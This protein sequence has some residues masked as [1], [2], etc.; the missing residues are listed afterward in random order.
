[1]DVAGVGTATITD[2]TTALSRTFVGDGGFS[3]QI[4][5]FSGSL[6]VANSAFTSYDLSHSFGP[7]SGPFSS[8]LTGGP[9]IDTSDGKLTFSSFGSTGTFTATPEPASLTLLGIGVAGMM[10]YTW[11][12]R[13]Q[14]AA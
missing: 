12:R 6:F 11:R 1:V 3:P 14:Q 10:G 8:N 9:P 7:V 13:R 5:G 2:S 4:G